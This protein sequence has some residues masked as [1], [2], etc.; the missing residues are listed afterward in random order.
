MAVLSM[1]LG[2]VLALWQDNVRR[3]MAYSSIAHAGYLLIGFAAALAGEILFMESGVVLEQGPPG[4]ILH[5]ARL[6][7]T[8][9][10]CAKIARLHTGARD[11]G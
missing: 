9:E 5:N 11:A 3:M 6:E 8:R 7:R 10:F 2:N 1:T 4:T